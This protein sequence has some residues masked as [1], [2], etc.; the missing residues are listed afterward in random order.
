MGEQG[1]NEHNRHS[2]E[3]AN[4]AV[5]NTIDPHMAGE[6]GSNEHNRHSYG[7]VNK[8]VMNTIDTHTAG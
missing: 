2:Y 8:E 7:R 5:M 1:S 6:Q 4:K 3:W